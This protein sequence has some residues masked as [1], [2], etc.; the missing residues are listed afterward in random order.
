MRFNLRQIEAFRAIMVTGS[1]SGA[2]R[3]LAVSQ[4]A[5]SRLLAHTE[6][7]LG[8]KLF[9]RIM[10]R[11]QPTPEA[12]RLYDQAEQVHQGVLRINHLVEELRE[13]GIGAMHVVASPSVSQALVPEA[14]GRFR[15]RH[16][17]TR[18]EFEILPIHDIVTKVGDSRVDLGISILPVE[19]PN[20]VCDPIMEGRL[21]VVLSPGH[22]LAQKSEI[23]PDD[24]A[25]YPLISY[26]PQTPYGVNVERALSQGKSAVRVNTIVRFTSVACAL[27]QAGAGVAIVDEFVIR[28]ETWPHLT[29]RPLVPLTPV[30]V[31]LLTQ[32]FK[33]LSRLAQTFVDI[34]H[35]LTTNPIDATA[36]RET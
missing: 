15:Q 18:I 29:S 34:M 25:P 1:V 11:V 10:G 17:D 4:P 31:H 28:G 30:R 13:H 27:V 16:P 26:G 6:D 8:L 20:I 19:D 23:S 3:L 12:R 21:T 9:E 32:R 14:I 22:P 36:Y 33:P 7:R 5:I 2:S 35:E 24:L